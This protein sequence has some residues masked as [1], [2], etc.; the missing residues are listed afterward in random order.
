MG[1]SR[2]NKGTAQRSD[3]LAKPVKPPTDPELAALREK[4]ILPVLKDLQASEPVSRTAAAKAVANIVQ[5]TKCRKLLLREQVVHIILTET[6]TDSSIE[7]RAAGWEILKL[8]T[9]E[10]EVDFCVHLFRVDLL[11]AIEHA[12]KRTTA[13]LKGSDAA[14]GKASKAEQQVGYEICESLAIII[15]AL[16]EAQDDILEAIVRNERIVEFLLTLVSSSLINNGAKNSALSCLMTLTEDNRQFVERILGD[17]QNNVFK[18]LMSFKGGN[19]FKAVLAC[20]V[21]HN[22][23]VVMEWD[24]SNPGRDKSSD[25]SLVP[26]LANAIESAPASA[27]SGKPASDSNPIEV[28]QVALEVL[29]SIGT[30]LQDTLQRGNKAGNDFK[31]FDDQD[32][33]MDADGDDDVSDDDAGKD[34]DEMDDDEMEADM[35]MVTGADDHPDEVTGLDDL[36]TLKSLVQTAIPTIIK[37]AK[38]ASGNEKETLLI[39][40]HAFTALNNIAWT[41]SCIDFSGGS[42]A[43][44]SAAWTPTAQMIWKETISHVLSSDT[45]DVSLATMVTSLAWALARTLHDKTPLGAEEPKKFMS[46]YHASTGL[47]AEVEDPF[48]GL[49]V[50]CIGV[51]GQLALDPAPLQLNREIGVFLVTVV[52]K[53]PETPAADTVEA[54]NQLFD[55]Y[56][57]ENQACDKEVFWKDNFIKYLEEVV[58]KVKAMAKKVDKRNFTELRMRADE[59]SLNLTRFI[60][61]K[62]KNKPSN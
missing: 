33:A 15:N 5:D 24:D 12:A 30:A 38:S 53:L 61:Y 45:S 31:G 27:S 46:L 57:D 35:D 32:T 14:F 56:G 54:L 40:G 7:S 29:A 4:S 60:Q 13:S 25:A 2:R 47:P 23:F 10:E 50:K 20:G 58:P 6:L 49:G 21:L 39:R 55:I 42:N 51:L 22:I 26:T 62:Q 59:A 34:G 28:L 3:P 19:D 36:P 9:Q 41:V 52:A 11:T 44:V 8:L 16:A 37:V 1:K 48:Q 17:T 43:P 18:H